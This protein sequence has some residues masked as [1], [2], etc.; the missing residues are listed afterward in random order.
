MDLQ[1]ETRNVIKSILLLGVH[2]V[3]TWFGATWG[4]EDAMAL[5]LGL[6]I[7]ETWPPHG[8]EALRL[9]AAEKG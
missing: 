5:S 1:L 8:H 3:A 6:Q 7:E 9:R 2:R 4:G